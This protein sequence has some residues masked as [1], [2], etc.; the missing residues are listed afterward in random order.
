LLV[1]ESPF[2]ATHQLLNALKSRWYDKRFEPDILL[3]H[4]RRSRQP[5]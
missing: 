5:R 3:R 1:P 4:V 2:R